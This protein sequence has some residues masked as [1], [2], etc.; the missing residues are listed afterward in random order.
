M[1][2]PRGKV[3]LG[4]AGVAVSAVVLLRVFPNARKAIIDMGSWLI[5]KCIGADPRIT[6]VPPFHDHRHVKVNLDRAHHVFTIHSV[7]E[8]PL[9]IGHLALAGADAAGFRISHDAASGQTIP[10]GE[11]RTVTVSVQAHHTGI[12]NATLDVPSD[13][14]FEP[15]VRVPL[16]ARVSRP[17]VVVISV[18]WEG[19]N[20]LPANIDAIANFRAMPQFAHIPL[21]H[22]LSEGYFDL[23]E[24]GDWQVIRNEMMRAMLPIDE[25]AVH[26]HCWHGLLN[27]AGVAP[28]GND[29]WGPGADLYFNIWGDGGHANP[30]TDYNAV[31]V[32]TILEHSRQG[33][34]I[35]GQFNISRSYRSGGWVMNAAVQQGVYAA[36]F[37]VDSSAVPPALVQGQ[38]LAD[39]VLNAAWGAVMTDTQP[40]LLP[41]VGGGQLKEIPDNCAL[42]DYVTPAQMHAVMDWA[43][44]QQSEEPFLVQIGFHQETAGTLDLYN[45]LGYYLQNP[46]QQYLQ[47]I[48]DVLTQWHGDFN[49]WPELEFLTVEQAANRFFG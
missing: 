39:G 45:N 9:H 31:D 20:L 1:S 28:S 5:Q 30:L 47:T 48:I 4:I 42:A 38:G 6:V 8:A 18:D 35:A 11:N 44:Q 32:Q 13:D 10:P 7:G 22:F 17:V 12:L 37:R 26:V 23:S 36:G 3:I 34:E 19:V 15:L 33:L 27:N 40:Y 41:A 21:T 43:L 24:A 25:C 46:P 2:S 14:P 49:I 16:T 29:N